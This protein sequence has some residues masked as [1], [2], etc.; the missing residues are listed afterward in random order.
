MPRL[1]IREPRCQ[2]GGLVAVAAV[3]L[4]TRLLPYA[5]RL[6]A[7]ADRGWRRSLIEAV[8]AVTCTA[9]ATI[10]TGKSPGEHGV[11]GNGWFF[12]DTGEV[13]PFPYGEERFGRPR[14]DDLAFT[15]LTKTLP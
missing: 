5:P 7:L 1:R 9:Q 6:Q 3:G 4:T 2:V 12:R 10:L 13:R 15:V 14:R 8:P 11:V